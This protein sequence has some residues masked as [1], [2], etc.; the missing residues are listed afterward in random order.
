M[1]KC[2]PDE[3]QRNPGGVFQGRPRISLRFMAQTSL[4]TRA[5]PVVT[6]SP[7]PGYDNGGSIIE[8]HVIILPG[9][10]PG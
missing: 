10:I 6:L 3:A 7:S 8:K 1:A 9:K 5:M 2:S 4:S